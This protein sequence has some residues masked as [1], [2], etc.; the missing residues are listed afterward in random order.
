MIDKS[1]GNKCIKPLNNRVGLLLENGL[2]GLIDIRSYKII[3]PA[4]FDYVEI[5][6]YL[7]GPAMV[8]LY[9][10]INY[11]T[12]DIRKN[13]CTP[14]INGCV[15][16]RQENMLKHNP[17]LFLKLDSVYFVDECGTLN[18]DNCNRLYTA[19]QN[20]LSYN[21]MQLEMTGFNPEIIKEK[22]DKIADA[23]DQKFQQENENSGKIKTKVFHFD[24]RIKE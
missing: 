16:E 1:L 8:H 14:I 5:D 7:E 10:G 6:N 19:A 17:A 24:N 18:I 15:T 3:A 11:Y 20:G 2:Y 13:D 23:I 9:D 21:K 12:S 4:H 22:T